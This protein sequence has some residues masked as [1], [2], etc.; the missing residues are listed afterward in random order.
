VEIS[1][2]VELERQYGKSR[3]LNWNFFYDAAFSTCGTTLLLLP[4]FVREDGGYFCLVKSIVTTKY[5]PDFEV[6]I[7]QTLIS[8]ELPKPF[9]LDNHILTPLAGDNHIR[10][11]VC[12]VEDRSGWI[13]PVFKN[14]NLQLVTKDED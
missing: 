9:Q 10:L 3:F 13:K 1:R 12:W 4:K 2:Q 5:L 14:M 11:P 8:L 6:L 7:N